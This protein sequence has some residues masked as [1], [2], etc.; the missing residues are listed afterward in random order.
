MFSLDVVDT[1]LFLD[2]PATTRLLYYDLGVRADDDGFIYPQKI[3]RMTGAGADDLKVLAAKGLVHIFDD[4]VMV[5]LHWLRNNKIDADKYTPSIFQPRLKPLMK[6]GTYLGKLS[7]GRPVIGSG[8]QSER[9]PKRS[10]E[11]PLKG[12]EKDPQ[13]RL[14]KDRVV[15]DNNTT[16]TNQ[17]GIEEM[18]TFWKEKTRTTLRNHVEENMKAYR[19]LKGELGGEFGV[20]LEAIRMIRSDKYQPRALQNKLINFIGL[21]DKLEEVESYMQGRVDHKMTTK[22]DEIPLVHMESPY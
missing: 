10:I 22:M 19:F 9:A 16:L 20:Y 11:G 13:Y 7:A 6:L 18:R 1:D 4:G 3:M 17:A 15:K 2:M 21:K 14:G 5:L 12:P 8:K